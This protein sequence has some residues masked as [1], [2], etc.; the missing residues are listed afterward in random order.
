MINVRNMRQR[1]S[2][3]MTAFIKS[4]PNIDPIESTDLVML[5]ICELT[6]LS[7]TDPISFERIQSQMESVYKMKISSQQSDLN[8]DIKEILTDEPENKMTE[9]SKT[10]S[11]GIQQTKR[12]RFKILN[13]AR[14]LTPLAKCEV[15]SRYFNP[16]TPPAR[17]SSQGGWTSLS[18]QKFR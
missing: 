15:K 14:S 2:K 6:P 1:S 11:Q 18:Y 7:P 4:Y 8:N 10:I 3:S 9:N 17:K 13:K 5:E 12:K 16:P